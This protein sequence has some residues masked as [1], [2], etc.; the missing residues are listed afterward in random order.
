[1]PRFLKARPTTSAASLSTPVTTST[2]ASRTV[3]LLRHRQV[4]DGLPGL[5]PELLGA[6][7]RAH[8]LGRLQQLLGRN[9]AAVQA[10]AADPGLFDHADGQPGGGAVQGG[11]IPAGAA[12]EDDDIEFL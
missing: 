7:H 2:S 11:G 1:M 9:A 12:S 8:D 5:H 10:R 6:G 4:E 3:T